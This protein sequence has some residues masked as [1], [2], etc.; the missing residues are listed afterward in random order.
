MMSL[1]RVM[2][3]FF[4]YSDHYYQALASEW[5]YTD[6]FLLE[7]SRRVLSNMLQQPLNISI[8]ALDIVPTGMVTWISS[9]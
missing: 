5:Y 6:R 2:S 1:L 3:D 7:I 8:K 4:I 9:T